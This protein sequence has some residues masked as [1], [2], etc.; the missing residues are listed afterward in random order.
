MPALAAD[1]AAGAL[2]ARLLVREYG[3]LARPR[4]LLDRPMAQLRVTALPAHGPARAHGVAFGDPDPD[5]GEDRGGYLAVRIRHD[6]LRTLWWPGFGVVDGRTVL[7][8]DP[9]P[10][11]GA[12]QAWLVDWAAPDR[13]NSADTTTVPGELGVLAVALLRDGDRWHL[14][15][16]DAGTILRSVPV[17]R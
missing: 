4:L 6:W 2:A 12:L 8:V 7:D 14:A 10:M 1:N 3:R 16:P 11:T 5:T 13:L 15:D 9:D 17:R